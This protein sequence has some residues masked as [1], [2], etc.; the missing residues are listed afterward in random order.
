MILRKLAGALQFIEINP[1]PST[2]PSQSPG[3]F[4]VCT[5]GATHPHP[6]AMM[7]GSMG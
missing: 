4:Y 1:D 6:E 3:K 5:D 2:T 7:G